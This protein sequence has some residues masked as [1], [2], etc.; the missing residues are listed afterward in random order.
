MKVKNVSA[1]LHHVGNVSIAPGEEKEIP[2]AFENSINKNDLVEVKAVA[3]A[4]AAKPTAPK[5]GAP[6]APVA[7][8]APAP[9]AE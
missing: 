6:V 2:K 3:P 1:R 5:P 9:A 7:P 4:P 8:V